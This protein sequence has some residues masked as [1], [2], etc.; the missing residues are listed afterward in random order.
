MKYITHEVKEYLCECCETPLGNHIGWPYVKKDENAYCYDCALKKGLVDAL[1]WL[2]VHGI[3]I[4]EKAYYKD[5]VITAFRKWGKAYRKD[6]VRVF[7]DVGV[8]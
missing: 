7:D 1:D 3:G 6:E 4:Y 5:G 2:D 8:Q